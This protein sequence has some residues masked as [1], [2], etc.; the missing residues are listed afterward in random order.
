[1]ARSDEPGAES[2]SESE[3]SG[4]PA[5]KSTISGK[6]LVVMVAVLVVGTFV[7]FSASRLVSTQPS[8]P[9]NYPNG[10]VTI[11]V[12]GPLT[13]N[14][15]S[16]GR[17]FV[18]GAT[19]A[20][21][22]LNARGGVAGYRVQLVTGD[23][24]SD[25]AVGT[26]TS[27]M[28]GMITVNGV[29][30]IVTGYTS[31]T[32]FE[33]G[34][35]KQYQL[36]YLLSADAQSTERIIGPNPDEYPTVFNIVP[37]YEVYRG[38]FSKHMTAWESAGLITVPSHT[39]AFITS[40][41]AYSTYISEGLRENF[42]A[43]GWSVT[44]YETVPF[45]TV[46]DWTPILVRIRANPPGLII[47]TDYIPS[48]EVAFMEQFLQSPTNSF[49]F[50]QYGPS[51]PEFV[52]DL[53][54]KANGVL[55][56]SAALSPY[57]SK[58]EQGGELLE[59]FRARF[60][61][62]PGLYGLT[63]YTEVMIWAGAVEKTGTPKDHLAVGAAILDW[64]AIWGPTGMV[65]FDPATHLAAS[66]FMPATFYQLWS[67]ERYCIAPDPFVDRAVQRPPW[68]TG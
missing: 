57:V 61:Y 33:V 36:P 53:G 58:Y 67:S 29:D 14:L 34:I 52:D 1:L 16:E 46:T 60:G 8:G 65:V 62:E 38:E 54:D 41:N 24:G 26:I 6:L 17:D 44:M 22:E 63:L 19:M 43:I 5:A 64:T 50:I 21:E 10:T 32:Q 66:E 30:A 59:K 7:G 9:F 4:E 27:V 37:S 18:N 11:G 68:M 42:T 48:N 15:A 2:G 13:G 12:T 47:N 20:V 55:Y 51:T 49:I 31:Q 35:A 28:E 23:V 56:N 45:G 25:F 3:P 39:V 40:D